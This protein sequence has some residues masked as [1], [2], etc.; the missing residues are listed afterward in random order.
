MRLGAQVYDEEARARE[1]APAGT[2]MVPE[3]PRYTSAA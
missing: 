2:Y 3:R 1:T